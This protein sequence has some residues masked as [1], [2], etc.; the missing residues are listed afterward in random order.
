MLQSVTNSQLILHRKHCLLRVGF[1]FGKK[2]SD[3][4]M[5]LV[6]GILKTWKVG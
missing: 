3:Y 1:I 4:V 5:L 6:A 2:L